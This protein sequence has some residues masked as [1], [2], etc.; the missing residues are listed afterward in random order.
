[1]NLC[2][3]INKPNLKISLMN[4]KESVEVL[5]L[6]YQ[7]LE[8]GALANGMKVLQMAARIGERSSLCRC[9]SEQWNVI[10]LS[11]GCI[12]CEHLL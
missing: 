4:T 5:K 12:W 3:E 7:A 9:S 10:P 1:M 6:Q 2:L 11:I 8:T